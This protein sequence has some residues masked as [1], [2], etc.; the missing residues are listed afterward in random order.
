M[1]E[2]V[3]IDS[4]ENIERIQMLKSNYSFLNI[5]KYFTYSIDAARY[6]RRNNVDVIF[7]NTHLPTI[8]GFE[9]YATFP[10][11]IKVV[12]FS[13]FKELAYKAYDLDA[14]D[15][16][17]LPYTD[18]RYDQMMDK[19]QFYFS[20]KR[21]IKVNTQSF[22]IQVRSDYSTI[23]VDLRE[24]VFI[25]TLDDYVKIH[26]HGKKPIL[27]LMSLKSMLDK[28]PELDFVRVHRS[29]IVSLKYIE[30]VRGKR[31]NIGM[32]ELPIGKS[33]EK[34]FFERY[35]KETF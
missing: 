33:H 11:T 9:F 35:V 34:I 24:I 29:Y 30:S 22:T 21:S 4:Q 31:I 25:E 23:N 14:I 20:N 3:V 19:V 5:V 18:L 16:L 6:I 15:Y 26:I 27:T 32:T 28:L 1:I 12:Y 17:L 7:M 2:C 10:K 8:S 13:S